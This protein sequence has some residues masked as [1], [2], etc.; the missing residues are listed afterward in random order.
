MS[1]QKEVVIQLPSVFTI[2]EC[3]NVHQEMQ[4]ALDN[5]HVI[6]VVGERVKKIDTAGIQL[7]AAFNIEYKKKNTQGEAQYSSVITESAELLGVNGVIH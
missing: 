1:A 5:G 2:S 6:C 7:I 3:A 4:N